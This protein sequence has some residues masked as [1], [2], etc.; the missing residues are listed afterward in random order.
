MVNKELGFSKWFDGLSYADKEKLLG[1]LEE[2]RRLKQECHQWKETCEILIN[3][4]LRKSITTSLKQFAEGKG[5][6]LDKL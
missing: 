4:K 3:P 5:I 1:A 2:I 6:P